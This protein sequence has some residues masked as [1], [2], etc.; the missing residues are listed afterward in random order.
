MKKPDWREITN[1]PA[2]PEFMATLAAFSR[3]AA[4]MP[5]LDSQG[6]KNTA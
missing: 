5:N 6:S 3:S 2:G 4:K 1:T